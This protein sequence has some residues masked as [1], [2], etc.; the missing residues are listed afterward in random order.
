MSEV[1]IGKELLGLIVILVLAEVGINHE[2]DYDKAIQLVDLAKASGAEAI[3]FQ[4][5]SQ[6]VKC[7]KLI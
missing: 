4:T 2:G 5:H 3:K 6:V 7:W 1:Q